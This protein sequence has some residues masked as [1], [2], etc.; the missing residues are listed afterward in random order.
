MAVNMYRTPFR[1]MGFARG[2]SNPDDLFHEHEHRTPGRFDATFQAGCALS[3]PDERHSFLADAG[4]RT[5][6][7]SLA[8]GQTA[9]TR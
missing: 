4:E 3:A 7:R 5:K 2:L 9:A 8:E 1:L 6:A